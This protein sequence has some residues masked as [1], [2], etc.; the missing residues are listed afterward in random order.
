M[1]RTGK[2]S[3][4]PSDDYHALDAVSHSKLEVF[5]KRPQLYYR[6]FV[7][8]TAPRETSNAF[9]FGQA[10]HTLI[11]EGE[12]A[13]AASTAVWTGGEKRKNAGAWKKFQEDNAAKAIITEDE[14]KDLG[15]MQAAVM[16]HPLAAQLM[17]GGETEITWRVNTRALPVP[18]QCRTDRFNALGAALTAGRPFVA[19]LKT[20]PSLDADEFRNFQKSFVEYGYHRQSGFYSALMR[21]L[22]VDL[23]D[24]FFVA[25]EKVEPFGVDVYRAADSAVGHGLTETVSDLEGLVKCYASGTWPN[26]SR[27]LINIEVP[28]WYVKK[29]P[30][31]Q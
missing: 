11:L 2:I 29:S 26:R 4:E 27:E 16:E 8:K 7:S 15:R 3:G 30:L 20:T 18:L 9:D 12:R 5:R 1:N 28:E 13:L 25:V 24:F 17:T 6:R 10:A 31:L 19:D 14:L 21:D 23:R 22:G